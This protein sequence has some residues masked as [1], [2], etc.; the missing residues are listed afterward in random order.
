MQIHVIQSNETYLL[1][2]RILGT[3]VELNISAIRTATNGWSY[4][5]GHC[6]HGQSQIY[7]ENRQTYHGRGRRKRCL[8]GLWEGD[9]RREKSDSDRSIFDASS[10]WILDSEAFKSFLQDKSS[11]LLWIQTHSANDNLSSVIDELEC[12]RVRDAAV[13]YSFC[14][15]HDPYRAQTGA[16]V[17][18]GLIYLLVEAYPFLVAWVWKEKPSLSENDSIASLIRILKRILAHQKLQNAFL[19]IENLGPSTTKWEQSLLNLI[20]SS[21]VTNKAKWIISSQ[22]NPGGGGAGRGPGRRAAGRGEEEQL[23]WMLKLDAESESAGALEIGTLS[24]LRY[25]PQ[26]HADGSNTSTIWAPQSLPSTELLPPESSDPELQAEGEPEANTAY[27]PIY[28]KLIPYDEFRTLTLWGGSEKD[29]IR[30]TIQRR[31]IHHPPNFE[32]LSYEWKLSDSGNLPPR[33]ITLNDENFSVGQNLWNALRFLRLQKG[34][35]RVLWIDA[36]CIQQNSDHDRNHQVAIMPLIYSAATSVIS[37]VG[38]T[39]SDVVKSSMVFLGE[40]AAAGGTERIEKSREEGYSKIL[41]ILA[42]LPRSEFSDQKMVAF[43][44]RRREWQD[45]RSFF[46]LRYWKRLWIIQEVVLPRQLRI[47]CEDCSIEWS[48]AASFLGYLRYA[49]SNTSA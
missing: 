28:E 8:S 2:S 3:D 20:R 19:V 4:T 24:W 42:R 47:Q 21:L 1:T 31:C 15:S 23:D 49:D 22:H 38:T 45:L 33:S 13:T 32:A 29:G 35:K 16:N 34:S 18:Y 40:M 25:L 39:M 9:P 30:C 48:V 44:K 43:K 17:L 5:R 14:R 37:W 11:R 27:K 36:I 6:S 12:R 10:R 41:G 7:F 46:S 26:P